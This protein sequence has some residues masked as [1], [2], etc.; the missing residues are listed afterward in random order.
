MAPLSAGTITLIS[1]HYVM[2]VQVQVMQA[3]EHLTVSEER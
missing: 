3:S 2:S 1:V